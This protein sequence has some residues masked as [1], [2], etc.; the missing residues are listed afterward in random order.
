M[1]HK[2]QLDYVKHSSASKFRHPRPILVTTMAA[3]LD[4]PNPIIFKAKKETVRDPATALWTDSIDDF[5]GGRS[6]DDDS[7]REEI[8]SDEIYGLLQRY[9][10]N[11][12]S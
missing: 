1:G 6:T 11:Q 5:D 8:D 7:E 4:N 2:P 12:A 10:S 3:I 9:T